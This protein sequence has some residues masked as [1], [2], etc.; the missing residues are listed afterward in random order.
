CAAH[1]QNSLV[2]SAEQSTES[3]LAHAEL[4]RSRSFNARTDMEISTMHHAR[5]SGWNR[6]GTAAE[7]IIQRAH[8]YGNFNDASRAR[9][10]MESQKKTPAALDFRPEQPASESG[11]LKSKLEPGL[12][13]PGVEDG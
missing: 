4:Q 3:Y 9:F 6:S 13:L 10:R 1:F 12:E 2:R 8:R 7:P 11:L 5:V